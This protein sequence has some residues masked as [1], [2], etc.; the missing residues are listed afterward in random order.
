MSRENDRIFVS[1]S[2]MADSAAV[3]WAGA[4]E[5][6]TSRRDEPSWDGELLIFLDGRATMKFWDGDVPYVVLVDPAR[7]N[8][9]YV[10][11]CE[12]E[13]QPP[14]DNAEIAWR[15][16]EGEPGLDV[17]ALREQTHKELEIARLMGPSDELEADWIHYL[18]NVVGLTDAWLA[19]SRS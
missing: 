9:S 12:T 3:S 4:S 13:D 8:G 11:V 5:G 19:R 2:Y 7:K 10:T 16:G 6:I 15:S 14:S 18:A 1:T 17:E